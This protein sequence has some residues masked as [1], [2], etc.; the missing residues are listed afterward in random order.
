LGFVGQ[1]TAE[2]ETFMRVVRMR[3]GGEYRVKLRITLDSVNDERPLEI[4]A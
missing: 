4:I 1:V 2:G 3:R